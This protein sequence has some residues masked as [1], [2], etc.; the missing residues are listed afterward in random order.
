MKLVAGGHC[1]EFAW[2]ITNVFAAKIHVPPKILAPKGV[3]QIGAMMSGEKGNTVTMIAAINAGGGFIPPML[4]FLRV[5]FKHFMLVAA[6]DGTIGGA[7]PSG[8]S[9]EALF[10]QFFKHFIRYVKPSKDYPTILLLD[11][12]ES[13]IQI[14]V[15]ELA[16]ENSVILVTFHPHT[17]HKFQ[18]LD[19]TVFG[20]FKKY[21]NTVANE[22]MLTPGHI[23]TNSIFLENPIKNAKKFLKPRCKKT[24]PGWSD[25]VTPSM[26]RPHPKAEPRK[27][28]RKG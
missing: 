9:N 27:E 6:P 3:K 26:I 7:N 21:Y 20:P 22:L 1:I 5:N 24:H 28:V 14:P 17:S 4:L 15:I 11:N 12:H 2:E 23:V 19:K 25:V 10:L 8:W 13:H 16:R 18:P